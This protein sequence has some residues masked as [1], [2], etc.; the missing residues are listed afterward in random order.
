MSKLTPE[1]IIEIAERFSYMNIYISLQGSK[2]TAL[3]GSLFPFNN[4][5][6]KEILENHHCAVKEYVFVP[7]NR[8]FLVRL[9]GNGKVTVG[10][11][12]HPREYQ[13]MFSQIEMILESPEIMD[14]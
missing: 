14:R 9:H 5:R 11:K 2:Q 6:L 13:K 1:K 7:R 12:A 3:D 8:G 10:P 4:D